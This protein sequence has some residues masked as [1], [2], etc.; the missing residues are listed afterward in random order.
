MKTLSTAS[1]GNHISLVVML[2]RLGYHPFHRDLHE[3][4]YK[5]MLHDPA[6][7]PV[8]T[9][10]VNDNL[11]V[12]YD[13]K[14]GIGGSIL[15]FAQYY[16][17]LDCIQQALNKVLEICG[18]DDGE[19]VTSN[20]AGRK[21]M[22]VKLPHYMISETLPVGSNAEISAFL[23]EAGMATTSDGLL[24]EV[25]YYYIDQHR[26]RKYFFAA[27]WKNENGGWEV[28]SAG[29]S[30][31][32]GPAGMAFIPADPDRLLIF[33]EFKDYLRWRAEFKTYDPSILILNS[34]RFADAARSRAYKYR[35][36]SFFA[37]ERHLNNDIMSAIR[38]IPNHRIIHSISA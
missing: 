31:C 32:I 3:C 34:N 15:E 6:V 19:S 9:L 13:N 5:S 36:A 26:R 4:Y 29:Y 17:K 23:H 37:G 33:E 38:Q 7:R 14:L 16:W 22:A 18:P 25:Y 21:R 30:G 10:T 12:W 35:E 8:P 24:R 28:R 11:G 2:S 27:G 1:R 20:G